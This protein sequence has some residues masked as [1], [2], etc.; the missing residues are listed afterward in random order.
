[1]AHHVRHRLLHTLLALSN[2]SQRFDRWLFRVLSPEPAPEPAPVMR[3]APVLHP[4][5]ALHVH[6][7]R[8]HV[9]QN[10]NIVHAEQKKRNFN[11]R[12]AVWLTDHVGSM[13]T[14]YIFFGIGCG[15]LVGV[16][17]GNV[18][19]AAVFGSLSSYVLQL[20]LLP[21]LQVGSNTIAEKASI[22][23]DEQF[24]AV[25]NTL[26]DAEQMRLH[27]LA[28]DKVLSSQNVVMSRQMDELEKHTAMLTDM[29]KRQVAPP[30]TPPV[31]SETSVPAPAKRRTR[32]KAPWAD[33]DDPPQSD[34]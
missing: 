5:H 6:E 20:V 4:T 27:L 3:E 21:V 30:D 28:Q 19:L 34:S 13:V 1:M 24:K 14:A 26:H 32:T 12:L 8:P 15:S 31:T 16:F 33:P 17:T 2:V 23:S 29:L 22:Q 7:P 11:T 25:E 18:V 9:V 10:A